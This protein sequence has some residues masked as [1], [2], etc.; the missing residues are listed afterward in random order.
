MQVVVD[1]MVEKAE[2]SEEKCYEGSTYLVSIVFTLKSFWRIFL[3][4]KPLRWI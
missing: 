2:E 4:Y 3:H 1:Q